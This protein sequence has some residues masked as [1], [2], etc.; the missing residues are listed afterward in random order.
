MPKTKKLNQTGS[1]WILCFQNWF[2]RCIVNL[3]SKTIFYVFSPKNS[4]CHLLLISFKKKIILSFFSKKKK[5]LT[6]HQTLLHTQITNFTT[7]LTNCILTMNKIN[8]NKPSWKI[9]IVR[10]GSLSLSLLFFFFFFFFVVCVDE[11][12]L[13]NKIFSGTH[14][15]LKIPK[16]CL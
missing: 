2:S 5:T 3:F 11:N 15:F 14:H 16:I 8:H 10:N 7:Q 13:S 12:R 4:L 1:F 9:A 6:I